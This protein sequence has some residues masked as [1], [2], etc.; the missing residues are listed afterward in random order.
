MGYHNDTTTA[1]D[2][3]GMPEKDGD[4]LQST[5][6]GIRSWKNIGGVLHAN[7]QSSLASIT[8][9]TQTIGSTYVFDPDL[10]TEGSNIQVDICGELFIANVTKNLG[11][12]IGTASIPL[13]SP[14]GTGRFFIK[15]LAELEDSNIKGIAQLH[16]NNEVTMQFIEQEV[17]FNADQQRIQFTT[18]VNQL[19]EGVVKRD[20]FII[21]QIV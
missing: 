21:R 19:I 4:F 15:L 8:T 16:W 20:I 2:L 7:Y 17:N 13:F 12:T 1:N 5:I 6:S 9:D 14:Q 11:L 3:L 18:Q 10:V